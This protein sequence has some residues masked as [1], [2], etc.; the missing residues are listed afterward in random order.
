MMIYHKTGKVSSEIHRFEQ[1][2]DWRRKRLRWNVM[3]K[4]RQSPSM[5][6]FVFVEVEVVIL[7]FF[8]NR[9]EEVE[10]D[11][12]SAVYESKWSDDFYRRLAEANS[13][14]ED[15]SCFGDEQFWR[16][17]SYKF[18][19]VFADFEVA[20]GISEIL[21]GF[22]DTYDNQKFNVNRVHKIDRDEYFARIIKVS[23]VGV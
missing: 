21:E 22:R 7:Q 12:W 6:E 20:V 23:V 3:R 2:A 18:A 4:L 19:E 10:L 5:G 14:T 16:T 17:N 11:E 9:F 15:L 13:E 1:L 8:S